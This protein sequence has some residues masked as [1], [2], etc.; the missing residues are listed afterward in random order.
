MQQ[1]QPNSKHPYIYLWCW[2]RY[3]G[4]L[5]SLLGKFARLT[6][7]DDKIA[8][9]FVA[10]LKHDLLNAL[11]WIEERE[12]RDAV[13]A[14]IGALERIEGRTPEE[15]DSYRAKAEQLREATR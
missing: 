13:R 3:Y 1:P 11:G 14:R 5:S 8:D 4:R 7:F 2:G 12:K 6:G 9:C 10:E 15:A